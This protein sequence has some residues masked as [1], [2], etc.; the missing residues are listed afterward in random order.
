MSILLRAASMNNHDADPNNNFST[1][2]EMPRYRAVHQ[3]EQQAYTYLIDGGTEGGHLTFAELDLQARKVAAML[4]SRNAR[5]ERMLLLYPTGL[6]F[7]AAF[8]GLLIYRGNCGSAA[9]L[10]M[11]S[12]IELLPGCVPSSTMYGR[13]RL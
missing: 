3:P 7:V 13:R 2:V 11:P 10:I 1:L 6:E 8:F 5:G 4:Q 12:R 9:A